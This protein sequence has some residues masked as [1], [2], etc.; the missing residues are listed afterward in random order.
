MAEKFI[1]SMQI[2]FLG[3]S[4]V[5]VILFALYGLILLFNRFSSRMVKKEERAVFREVP[6]E[7]LSPRLAAAISAAVN[8]HRTAN[9]SCTGSLRLGVNR[10]ETRGSR[11][12]TAG[13]KDLLENRVHLE[14]SRREKT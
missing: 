11:W 6:D 5:M 3:F 2:I 14:I 13:R 8:C 9:S 10:P 4:V 1:F 7:V 12:L